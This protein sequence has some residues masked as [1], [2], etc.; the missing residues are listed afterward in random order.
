LARINTLK[1][2]END[3]KKEIASLKSYMRQLMALLEEWSPKGA[4]LPAMRKFRSL[5]LGPED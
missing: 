5:D 1:K 2:V 3:R 4:D